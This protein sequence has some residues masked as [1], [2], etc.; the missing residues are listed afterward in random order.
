MK[1]NLGVSL[2]EL[3]TVI[4]IVII[5][6]SIAANFQSLI[7]NQR[8]S[9]D[10][11]RLRQLIA[12]ARQEAIRSNTNVVL[13]PLVNTLCVSDWNNTIFAFT[14][15]NGNEKLDNHERIIYQWP[16]D[17]RSVTLR[18]NNR[19]YLRF[20]AIGLNKDPG[21][22]TL[23]PGN[24]EKPETKAAMLTIN[25]GGRSYFQRDNNNDGIV[26]QYGRNLSC[27]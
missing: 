1:A 8:V 6:A 27:P 23:C 22:F 15:D 21:S 4:S 16:S 26:D 25:M 20:K 13:C 3:L 9:S 12:T 11:H 19:R 10:Q 7:I 17:E 2:I 5:M 24:I 18:W 14:D